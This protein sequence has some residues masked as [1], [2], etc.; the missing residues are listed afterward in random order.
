MIISPGLRL[1]LLVLAGILPTWQKFFS[2]SS[3]FTLRGLAAPILESATVACVI[4]IA[5]TRNPIVDGEPIEAKIV[6][7]PKEP[8]KTEEV[9]P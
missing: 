9:K 6:N 8:V 4:V 5:R 7:T 2:L 1:L 3:D